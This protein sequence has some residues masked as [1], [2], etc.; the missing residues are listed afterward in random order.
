MKEKNRHSLR[1]AIEKLPTYLA[2]DHIWKGISGQL[3]LSEL[4]LYQAPSEAWDHISK[5]LQKGKKTKT[6]LLWAAASIAAMILLAV[7]LRGE[8]DS[9]EQ[10]LPIS[11]EKE[12]KKAPVLTPARQATYEYQLVTLEKDLATCILSLD[13]EESKEARPKI[14][15]YFELVSQQDHYLTLQRQDS[16]PEIWADSLIHVE[17]RRDQVLRAFFSTYCPQYLRKSAHK[18]MQPGKP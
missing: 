2:P 11:L 12:L 9:Y 1:E 4:P 8:Q 3:R 18:D 16:Q 5:E 13:A 17:Q 15:R 10:S 7:F 6:R 14:A